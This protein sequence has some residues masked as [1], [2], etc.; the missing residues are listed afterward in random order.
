MNHSPDREP[1]PDNTSLETL[2]H[3]TESNLIE[4]PPR[5]LFLRLWDRRPRRRIRLEDSEEPACQPGPKSR[6]KKIIIGLLLVVVLLVLC[7]V[8]PVVVIVT[9]RRHSVR[10]FIITWTLCINTGRLSNP[11]GN[12]RHA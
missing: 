7:V 2:L 10:G 11:G 8:V 3:Q 12:T 6:T 1:G 5:N 4:E 9:K